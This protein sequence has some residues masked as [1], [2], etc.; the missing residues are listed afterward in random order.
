MKPLSI[1]EFLQAHASDLQ[2][3]VHIDARVEDT[4]S[5]DILEYVAYLGENDFN[6][7]LDTKC[8]WVAQAV[9]DYMLEEKYK[10]INGGRVI[11][12]H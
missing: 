6:Y 5:L 12:T 8:E 4:S 11:P 3:Q 7:G 1:A 9:Y 2:T 10:Q